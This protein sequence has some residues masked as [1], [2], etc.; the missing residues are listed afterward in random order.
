MLTNLS[1]KPINLA[2]T[3]LFP[4][5]S[6]MN[7][8]L[9]YLIILLI[10]IFSLNAVANCPQFETAL[11]AAM[12]R[13]AAND[14]SKNTVKNE[15]PE[16]SPVLTRTE[17]A[18]AKKLS[19]EPVSTRW[20]ARNA[21][22][23]KVKYQAESTTDF[24]NRTFVT[25]METD[26][27]IKPDVIYFDVENAVQKKLNDSLVDDKAMVD[28]INNSFMDN[29]L[30][31]PDLMKVMSTWFLAGSGDTA[32]EANMAAR[33]ARKAGYKSGNSRSVNFTEQIA[34]IHADVSE[35]E[36]IRSILVFYNCYK[37]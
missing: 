29:L 3:I 8:K 18:I 32:L 37:Q 27:T 11:E 9:N 36:K 12:R 1:E 25:L 5:E 34:S 31:Y 10:A 23:F 26:K 13:V 6:L 33:A 24:N 21:Q 7:A 19:D 2:V 14:S 28:A 16:T 30:E 35:I 17:N 22:K 20:G 15:A 4:S